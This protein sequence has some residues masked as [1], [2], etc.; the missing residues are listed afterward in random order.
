[1]TAIMM[2]KE[3]FNHNRWIMNSSLIETSSCISSLDESKTISSIVIRTILLPIE[4][5]FF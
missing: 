3:N 5:F 1:M 2:T 4:F